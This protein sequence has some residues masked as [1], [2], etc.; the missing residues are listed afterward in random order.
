MPTMLIMEKIAMA[1]P[2][3][4][5][6]KMLQNLE[7]VMAMVMVMAT[8]ESLKRNFLLSPLGLKINLIQ[9]KVATVYPKNV[10]S[11]LTDFVFVA[12]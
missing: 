12:G 9:A 10:R 3:T 2:E 5:I 7:K 4:G 6:L 11:I 1:A 8:K